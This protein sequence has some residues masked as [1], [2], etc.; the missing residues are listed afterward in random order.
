LQNRLAT[1]VSTDN[2]SSSPKR[3]GE[4]RRTQ[5]STA[6]GL[7]RNSNYCRGLECGKVRSAVPLPIARTRGAEMDFHEECFSM[8]RSIARVCY[9]RRSL[10]PRFLSPELVS[11][12]KTKD[13]FLL[14]SRPRFGV[15]EM[16][17]SEAF[18]NSG[19][20]KSRAMRNSH[21]QR[22]R[23]LQHGTKPPDDQAVR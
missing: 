7:P 1:C 4:E 22:A 16:P 14:E 21:F 15:S 20:G 8:D 3:R 5:E 10:V 9:S 13:P 23:T 6:S 17:R 11:R 18:D 2:S 12:G 19:R